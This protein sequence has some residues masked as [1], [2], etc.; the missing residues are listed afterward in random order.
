MS[1]VLQVSILQLNNFFFFLL[2]SF[3]HN[4]RWMYWYR[5]QMKRELQKETWPIPSSTAISMHWLTLWG[6][7]PTSHNQSRWG[8]Q[9]VGGGVI[10]T[11]NTRLQM[12]C[13]FIGTFCKYTTHIMRSWKRCSRCYWSAV[14]CDGRATCSWSRLTASLLGRLLRVLH[15]TEARSIRRA[16][17]WSPMKQECWSGWFSR[18]S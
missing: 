18:K 16:V 8:H 1:T 2:F 4:I 17:Q 14:D 6:V 11:I 9:F 15:F 13:T 7:T 3:L 10:P 5:L 12:V